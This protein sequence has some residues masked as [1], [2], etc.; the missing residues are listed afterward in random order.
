MV[1]TTQTESALTSR[2]V[3]T[4]LLTCDLGISVYASMYCRCSVWCKYNELLVQCV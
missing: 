3:T 1:A 2:S 4:K